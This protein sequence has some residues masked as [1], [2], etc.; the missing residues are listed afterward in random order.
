MTEADAYALIL[1]RL[2]E[3]RDDIANDR[4][5]SSE[6]RRQTHERI[7]ELIQQIGR[8]ETTVA[9]DGKVQAQTRDEIKMLTR[10][11]S[12]M[13]PVADEWRR[14]QKIGIGLFGLI[15]VGGIS[16]GGFLAAGGNWLVDIIRHWLRLQ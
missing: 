4:E 5:A 3:L 13:E 6:S 11:V 14:I 8:L 7:D 16:I 15:A 9:V 2:G 1:Q 12:R 10:R